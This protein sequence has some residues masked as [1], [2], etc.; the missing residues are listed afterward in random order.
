MAEKSEVVVIDLLMKNENIKKE[1][2]EIMGTMQDYLGDEYPEERR[3]ASGGDYLTCER[4]IGA[5]RHMMDGNTQRERL[6]ILEPMSEDFHF[7]M[8]IIVV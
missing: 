5:Q 2:L 3:V 1:M 4:Q 6:D 8:C 7:L